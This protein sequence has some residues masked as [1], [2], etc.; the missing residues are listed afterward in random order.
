LK[1]KRPTMGLFRENKR[2]NIVVYDNKEARNR[3]M[4]FG[5]TTRLRG[6]PPSLTERRGPRKRADG[7]YSGENDMGGGW[8]RPK[9]WNGERRRHLLAWVSWGERGGRR[10]EEDG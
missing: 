5:Q 6:A 7:V 4:V 10:E 8:E 3:S 1:K 9:T 2:V